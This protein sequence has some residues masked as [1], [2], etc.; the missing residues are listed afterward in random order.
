[1][2]PTTF[3]LL[4]CSHPHSRWHLATLRLLPEV[5]RVWL[6]DPDPEAARALAGEAGEMLAGVTD[7]LDALRGRVEVGCA[8]VARRDRA[9]RETVM[10]AALA[11]KQILTDKP[12]APVPAALLPA[13]AAVREAA[14][15][16]GV[17]YQWRAHP[18]ARDLRRLRAE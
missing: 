12:M 8:S 10:R 3:A 13:L 7:D 15:T 1:M 16:L 6:W 4:G 14:V 11:G 5:E 9:T 18:I 2:R 17:C